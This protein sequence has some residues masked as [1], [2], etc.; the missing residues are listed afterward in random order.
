MKKSPF[1]ATF[2]VFT[3][4]LVLTVTSQAAST[5]FNQTAAGPWDYNDSANW[6][7]TTLNG[8]WDRSLTLTAGQTVQFAADTT[9]LTGLTFNYSGNFA[10]VLDA[11]AAGTRN[12]T[13]AGDISVNTSG[14]TSA[15]V[16]LGNA[17][18]HLNV[19]LGAVT[20]TMTVAA[21]RTLSLIDVVSNG[22]I[23]KAGGGTLTLTG[24]N[25]YT[26]TTTI[27]GGTFIADTASAGTVLDSGSPLAFTASGTFQLKG[28]S[29]Q[30]RTQTLNGLT[31]T[32][33][34]ATIDANNTGTSTTLDLRGMGGTLTTTRSAGATADFKATTGTFGTSAV[35]NIHDANDVN[36]GILGAWATVNGGADWAINNGSDVAAAYTAYNTLSGTT[37]SSSATTNY[38]VATNPTTPTGNITMAATG[39]IDINTLRIS[40]AAARTIDVRNGT[41]QGILRF[42]PV[43]GI[44]TSGGSHVI[45]VAGS[46]TA[47]TIT[48]GGATIDTAGE[49]IVNNATALT[50]NSVIA[51]NGTGAVSVTKSGAG[52]LTLPVANSFS[53]GFTLNSGTLT[54]SNAAALGAGTFTI[55]GGTVSV[56]SLTLSGSIPIVM[57]GDWSVRTSNSGAT[58][59]TGAGGITL[60]APLAINV[61]NSQLA[62]GGAITSPG[63]AYNA[64]DISFTRSDTQNAGATFTAGILLRG[65]QVA[66]NSTLPNITYSSPITDGGNNYGM[67]F[68]SPTGY[69]LNGLNSFT[70]AMII[71]S[72]STVVLNAGG[73][74]KSTAITINAGGTLALGVQNLG[75]TTAKIDTTSTLTNNG[76]LKIGDNV[77]YVQGTDFPNGIA[78]AGSVVVSGTRATGVALSGTNTYGGGTTV[79]YTGGGGPVVM[80]INSATAIGSGPLTLSQAGAN[81]ATINNTSGVAITLANNNL[82]NW[83]GPFTFTGTNSLNLGTGAVTLNATPTVNV[84]ANTLT[85]GGAIG[86]GYGLTKSGAGTLALTGAST[87]GGTLSVLQ[88]TLSIGTI[89]DSSSNGVLGNSANAVALGNTGGVTGTL[90]YTGG[91]ASSTKS[92]TLATGGTGAF[93]IDGADTTLTLSGVVSGSGN[94]TKSGPGT[95]IL[96]GAN[97]FTG[98]VTTTG[99][100]LALG[101]AGALQTGIYTTSTG[102]LDVTGFPALTLGGLGGSVNL[103][104]AISG[105]GSV[106]G[107]TLNPQGTGSV[108]YSGVIANGSGATTL[109][110][111]GTG[112]QILSGANTY[113]GATSVTGGLLLINSPGV[114]DAASAVS[115][116][117]GAIGGTGTINGAVTLSGTG[118]IDLRSSSNSTGTLTLGS[119]LAITGAAGAN[120]LWF[121]LGANTAFT[122]M[123]AVSGAVSVANPVLIR[124]NTSL[125]NRV[126][127]GTYDLLTGSSVPAASNFTLLTSAA[128][129]QTFSLADST[130]SV[131]KLTATRVTAVA[132]S[133]AAFWAGGSDS[134]STPG[135][136]KNALAGSAL[137]S[138]PD[139]QSNVTFSADSATNTTTNQVDADFDINSLTF[140]AAAGGVTIGGSRMLT[141]EAAA[142][143]GNTAGNGIIATAQT[144]GTNTISANIGLALSQSWNIGT[145][146]TLTISG[147]ITD[148]SGS[149]YTL[150]KKGAGTLNLDG[151]TTVGN[152]N[153]G[154]NAATCGAVVV[155]SGGSLYV[156]SGPAN[157]LLVGVN[158]PAA[159]NT[160]LG[161]LDVSAAS[162]FVANV[163]NLFVG[164]C[165]TG[166]SSPQ[167]GSGTLK[168]GNSTIT[169]TN[170]V[171][172]GTEPDANSGA[173]NGGWVTV[174]S[175]TTATILT[176]L[177]AIGTAKADGGGGNFTLVGTGATLN[178]GTDSSRT[179]LWIGRHDGSPTGK[180]S[181]GTMNLATGV[182]NLYLSKLFLGYDVLPTASGGSTISGTLTLSG[183]AA[184][185]LDISG[186]GSV[187]RLAYTDA[188]TTG[189][190]VVNGTLTIGNLDATSAITSTDNG[191]AILI[192]QKVGTTVPTGI[193]NL[194]GGTLTITTTGSAIAGGGGTST[195]NLNGATLKA[196]AA[197]SAFLTGLTNARIYAGGLT[198][199]TGGNAIT[200]PQALVAAP[201]SGYGLPMTSLTSTA[202]GS[203][204]T[205]PPSVSFNTPGG[206]TPA[207]GVAT[208]NGGGQVT[209]IVITS[210]GSGYTNGGT[211]TP[212]LS[213]GGGTGA[214]FTAPTATVAQATGGLTKEGLGTLTLSGVNTYTG[215]TTVSDG[216][217]ALASSGGLKF[218]VTDAASNKV[219]GSG[220]ATFDGVF[221]IDTNAVTVITGSWALVD[222]TTK[223]FTSNFSVAGFTPS[224]D[225]V[226]WT[227]PHGVDPEKVWTFSET[228][229]TLVLGNATA[230]AY[231]T[232]ATGLTNPAFD[233]DSDNN[234]IDNGLQWILGGSQTQNDVAAIAPQE[235]LDTTDLVLTFK[236]VDASI[237][238]AT[239][240]AEWDVDLAGSWTS[241]PI[242][243]TAA[244][245]YNYPYGVTVTVVT[246]D[247]ASDDIT[248]RIPRTNAVDGKLFARLKAVK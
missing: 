33:G 88:G 66:N 230:S 157:S 173:S 120:P 25:S 170:F 155:G 45:G 3:H 129:G 82:Q 75:A 213:G 201:G 93:Q 91:T 243:E 141:I 103:A 8:L 65:N 233:F 169:A 41:T 196:G 224:G 194:N 175:G 190:D 54:P 222:V 31:L 49:L 204:Y 6:V 61:T 237:T 18:N 191:T 235:T 214:T 105:Y 134:W 131:V 226:K 76:V 143:N 35:I 138:A 176:P 200:V 5:G 4:T 140:N 160:N 172:G 108:T 221:T 148:L 239:L 98:T 85:V 77:A 156:G 163:G 44:L 121:D 7:D 37:L 216:T 17:T 184:N 130:A 223:S 113:T 111:T 185:K 182:A 12:L 102:G 112:T 161:T 246:N 192:A 68:S 132:G 229:G 69:T 205:S 118:G 158:G 53:G 195:V 10:L 32:N 22:G 89:N 16:T 119:T 64:L 95:L 58:F 106:T 90:Q 84:N 14:G 43:G 39:T 1:L 50:V 72:G 145:G 142:I 125:A 240:T 86:G 136:W 38:R 26:G 207:T 34:A 147:N 220:A 177:M 154:F 164:V 183:N 188:T 97:T 206:G 180:V 24:A 149:S 116:S 115:V 247:A 178:L 36:T 174:A 208:I 193:L 218:I 109:T 73:T 48:A 55:N 146:G 166:L 171:V 181:P 126:V 51:N 242:N 79:I 87:F 179:A 209:G 241:V 99:G 162:N 110:K 133:A 62:L 232:W 13:L 128:Y 63:S 245:T 78:G 144:S 219:T 212:T 70:G 52:Q 203:G 165:A 199:D 211:V 244:G 56:S 236:R 19:N 30:T 127:A 123:I 227:K 215:N 11:S 197:S 186:A 231:D 81:A 27:A 202:G 107:L 210:P 47:G 150:S 20:R 167:T 96:A 153:V 2:I 151:T 228:A 217:L 74:V 23:I 60:N 152:L 135:N 101:S 80:N 46:G 122:D 59:N 117:A 137:T 168:L 15:N 71:N 21:N 104:T 83:N 29:G 248:V 28:L 225:G 198:L 100:T 9:L 114:L 189:G 92:F 94:L 159:G 187:V 67:T 42:G 57:N 139:Y 124:L 238:E 234:G 40:D